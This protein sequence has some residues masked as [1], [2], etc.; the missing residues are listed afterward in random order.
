MWLQPYLRKSAAIADLRST[1]REENV[2]D[3]FSKSTVMQALAEAV[4]C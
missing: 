4:T 2:F 3:H 1:C